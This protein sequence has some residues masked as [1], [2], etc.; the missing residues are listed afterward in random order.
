MRRAL[1]F[2]SLVAGSAVLFGAAGG[3]ERSSTRSAEVTRLQRHFDSVDLELRSRNVAGLSGRQRA[4]RNLLVG[5]LR[6]YRSAAAFPANDRFATPTPFFRDSRGTLCAMAYLI[7]RSGRGD[8]VDKVAATR[9]N[10]Y[11]RELVDDPAL[12]LWLD[13]VGL[14]AGE[15]GR[16]QPSYG[17]F[18]DDPPGDYGNRVKSDVALVALGLGSASLAASAINVVK[19]SH[20][21]GFV[22]ILVG[23]LA[24]GV[25]ANYVGENEGTNRVAAATIGLGAVSVGTGVYA[26]VAS[27]RPAADRDRRRGRGRNRRAVTVLPDVAVQQGEPRLGARFA[28]RF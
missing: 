2:V 6:D 4:R 18:P 8:L 28:A 14:T 17:G 5:W 21:S 7:D 25:G 12:V 15:A 10:A 13:S 24:V 3:G 9:N 16:I 19:P 20:A 26:L 1:V 22:G 23:A 27:R 11:I